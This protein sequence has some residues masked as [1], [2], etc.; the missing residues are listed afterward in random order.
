RAVDRRDVPD[1]HAAPHG[2]VA[3]PRLR[4]P[5]RIPHRLRAG[6]CTDAEG[7]GARGGPLPPL[8]DGGGVVRL[9][10]GGAGSR[11]GLS[12]AHTR[13][14]RAASSLSP[15]AGRIGRPGRGRPAAARSL[16][17]R[18]DG[19]RGR[20]GRWSGRRQWTE[21]RST[22][23]SSPVPAPPAPSAGPE[24]ADAIPAGRRP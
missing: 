18:G 2:R 15:E 14:G 23:G 24:T 22:R 12:P 11:P 8:P 13:G 16:A 3:R 4:R 1:L 9:A 17:G 20:E 19:D 21:R 6:G 7:A 10:G 5:Q